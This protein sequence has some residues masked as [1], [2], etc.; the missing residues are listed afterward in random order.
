MKRD[1]ERVVIKPPADSNRNRVTLYTDLMPL[2][3]P[4]KNVAV[5]PV[6][7]RGSLQTFETKAE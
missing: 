6:S 2:E 1:I 7:K 3:V 5:I 4:V